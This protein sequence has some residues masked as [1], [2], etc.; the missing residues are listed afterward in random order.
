MPPTTLAPLTMK[1]PT[2]KT[3]QPTPLVTIHEGTISTVDEMADFGEDA[4]VSLGQYFLSR[5]ERAVIK[6]GT[7]RSREETTN[8]GWP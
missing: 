2:P 4:V 6:K 8:K 3:P 1:I 7:K 5:K